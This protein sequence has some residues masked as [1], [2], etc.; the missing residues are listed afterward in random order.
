MILGK[1]KAKFYCYQA[2]WLVF[3]KNDEMSKGPSVSSKG[4]PSLTSDSKEGG[5]RK[6]M[7][8]GSLLYFCTVFIFLMHFLP[9]EMIIQSG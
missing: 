3:T 1:N 8:K 9:S 4:G 5:A 6:Q 2:T 7:R